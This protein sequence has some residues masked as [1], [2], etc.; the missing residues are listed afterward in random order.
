MFNNFVKYEPH[1]QYFT[2][3][4]IISKNFQYRCIVI[5]RYTN[6]LNKQAFFKNKV[7]II[8]NKFKISCKVL[9]YSTLAP[10]NNLYYFIV[11]YITI[12]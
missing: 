4:P 7:K 9:N 1:F 12:I 10:E 11:V 5:Q 6:I 2:W 8:E 3:R